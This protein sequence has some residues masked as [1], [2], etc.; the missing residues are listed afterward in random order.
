MNVVYNMYSLVEFTQIKFQ[1]IFKR[2]SELMANHN[3]DIIDLGSTKGRFLFLFFLSCD[4]NTYIQYN[5]L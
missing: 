3:Y 5:Y 1:S 2:I 4:F